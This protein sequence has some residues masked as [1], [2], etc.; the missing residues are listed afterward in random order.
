[1]SPAGPGVR[2]PARFDPDTWEKDVER[3]TP[4]GRSA[5]EAAKVAY[6]HGGVP[7]DRLRPCDPEGRDGNNLANCVKVYVP[8]PDG[9]WGFVFKV[10]EADGRLR[11]EFLAFGVRHHPKT[12]HAPDLYDFAGERVAEITAKDLRDEQPDTPG[13]TSR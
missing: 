10:V 6:E 12:A 3:S 4:A 1:M 9:K 11:L 5:A 2:F 13:K 7:R 8:H